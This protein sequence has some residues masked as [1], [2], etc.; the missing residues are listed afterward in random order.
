MAVI[1]VNDVRTPVVLFASMTICYVVIGVLSAFT[2]DLV[3]SL[4]QIL[5]YCILALLVSWLLLRYGNAGDDVIS[6]I[7]GIADFL[8][9]TVSVIYNDASHVNI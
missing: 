5:A 2:L 1:R 8:L 6:A 7:D 3:S 4:V 9:A